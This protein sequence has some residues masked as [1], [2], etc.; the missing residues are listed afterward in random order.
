MQ[1]TCELDSIH[2]DVILFTEARTLSD[3][4]RIEGHY[5]LI[6]NFDYH[7]CSGTAILVHARHA[8][9]VK[10]IHRFHDRLLA[11][12]LRVGSRVLRIASVYMPHAGY[13]FDELHS[14]YDKL[15]SLL[16]YEMQ[17]RFD[18][19]VGGDSNTVVD[20]GSRGDLLNELMAMFDLQIANR[21]EFVEDE[22]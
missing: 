17:K 15:L 14:V 11:I 13:A 9:N 20:L 6:L 21:E 16:D 4:F 18:L 1:V 12:D 5:R 3:D 10:V 8:D 2:W 22:H 7:G 19:I